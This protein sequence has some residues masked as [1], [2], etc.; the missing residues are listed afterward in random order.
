[1]FRHIQAYL[2]LCVTIA[3]S[4]LCYILSPDI[5]W[6]QGF[7]KT[8][9]KVQNIFRTL[10]KGIIQLYSDI[11]CNACTFRTLCNAC[12]R[13]NM[14]YSKS[15]NIQNRS[16]TAFWHMPV[17]NLSYL[18]KF[19]KI[20]NPDIF[21]TWYIFRTLSETYK[22]VF[23]KIVIF[24][25][26]SILYLWNGFKYAHLSMSTIKIVEW[27]IV[28]DTLRT[29]FLIIN[30]D[31]F[32]HIHILFRDIQ[33]YCDIIRTLFNSSLFRTLPRSESYI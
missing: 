24:P 23:A 1:M 33:S 3:Y 7:F 4:Q 20:Q 21:K 10:T 6:T 2:A 31:I 30:S 15:W 26:C 18:W 29:L 22:E 27:P 32:R 19:T 25:K 17:R 9:W 11:L 28:W 16:I 5:F 14:A 13:R 12:I 8:L